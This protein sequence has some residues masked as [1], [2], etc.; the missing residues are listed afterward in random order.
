VTPGAQR[1][2]L[3][4]VCAT[5]DRPDR[6]AALLESLREQ[7][8]P[9][10]SFE[11]VIVDDGSGPGTVDVLDRAL[12]L[13]ST[14]PVLRV[15]RNDVSQGPASARNR[16]WREGSAELIA[17]IDDDCVATPGW[18]TAGLRA[19]NAHP[20]DIIQGRVEPNPAEVASLGPFSHTIRVTSAGPEFE[21]ANIF[22][23]R[24]M[25]EAAG[26]FNESFTMPVSEDTDLAWR[27]LEQGAGASMAAD[28]LAYHAVLQL[29]PMAK[30][31]RARR[32]RDVPV[33]YVRHPGLRSHL[34]AGVFWHRGHLELSCWLL[35][36]MLPRRL[37]FVRRMLA[38]A[39]TYRLVNRRSGP[40]I[41]PYLILHDLV[42]M[43]AVTQG[44]I[45]NRVLIL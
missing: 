18:V 24:A 32:W 9:D 8:A 27:V 35:A 33:L 34:V 11:V 4:V 42:E 13:A 45:K 20:G 17:F 19:A 16:G 1:L 30:L 26:G 25:L 23:R 40:L 29:G 37:S 36:F 31:R 5:K 15:L 7:D 2:E 41:A 12:S 6:L 22:Y 44:A 39:Y 38:A 10:D 43:Q 21:T 14:G 3:T 28:A